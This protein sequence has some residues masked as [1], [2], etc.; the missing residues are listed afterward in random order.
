ML[1]LCRVCE[2][3]CRRV[4]SLARSV[5]RD[6][7]ISCCGE[8]EEREVR[9]RLVVLASHSCGHRAW[10]LPLRKVYLRIVLFFL[11]SEPCWHS[12]FI[13][14]EVH[15]CLCKVSEAPGGVHRRIFALVWNDVQYQVILGT[16]AFA[17]A[18]GNGSRVRHT[19]LLKEASEIR[20]GC[21]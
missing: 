16:D 4:C 14:D 21:A 7:P 9:T 13:F 1:T 10:I 20:G 8:S 17:L 5:Q 18:P 15:L 3:C 2:S 12:A 19:L 11:S 6:L